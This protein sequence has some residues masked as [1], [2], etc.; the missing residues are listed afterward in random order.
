MKKVTVRG[1]AIPGPSLSTRPAEA[2]RVDGQGARARL[3][4]QAKQL[5]HDR[6]CK[7]RTSLG[8]AGVSCLSR[9][10]VDHHG[11]LIGSC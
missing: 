9:L 6:G 3:R 5:A 10:T 11:H 7:V 2:A 1:A 4:L 8:C